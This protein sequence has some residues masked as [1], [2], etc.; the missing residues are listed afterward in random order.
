MPSRQIIPSTR[1]PEILDWSF[2]WGL[3]TPNL[4]NLQSWGRRGYGGSGMVPFKKALVSSYRP[5]MA[6][7]LPST[8]ICVSEILPLLCSST[9]LFPAPPVVS[10]KFPHVLLEVRGWP[11]RWDTKNKGVGLIVRATSFQDFHPVWSWSTKVDRHTDDMQS[12]DRTS[13]GKNCKH[14]QTHAQTYNMH[15]NSD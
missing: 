12:Q 3:Q 5:S 6:T 15:A 9:P 8:C 1:L 7:F 2:G 13:R 10:S 14:L 11:C 4:W